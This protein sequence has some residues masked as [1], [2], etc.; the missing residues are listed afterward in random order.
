ML[1]TK[2]NP[3][4][5]KYSV[6]DEMSVRGMKVLSQH[7]SI[8]FSVLLKP[9]CLNVCACMLQVQDPDPPAVRNEPL[10]FTVTTKQRGLSLVAR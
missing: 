10:S 8:L 9:F 2:N 7:V 3:L 4:T 1:H 5:G 6:R